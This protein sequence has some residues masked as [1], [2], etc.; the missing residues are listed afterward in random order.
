MD[1]THNASE[2]TRKLDSLPEIDAEKPALTPIGQIDDDDAESA[3]AYQSLMRHRAERR[4]KKI[5]RIAIA[6]GVVAGIA[7]ISGAA[8]YLAKSGREERN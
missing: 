8:V 5:V 2:E 6:A 3:A 7:V 1:Q 4:R